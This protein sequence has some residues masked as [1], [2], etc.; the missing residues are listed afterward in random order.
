[1]FKGI[2]WFMACLLTGC[3]SYTPTLVRLDPSGLNVSKA[4]K[5]DLTLYVEEYATPSKSEIAFDEDLAE[6]GVLPL[7]IQVVNGGQDPY[8]AT[9]DDIIVRGDTVL[10]PLTPA[11]AASEAKRDAVGKAIGWS[12]IVPII[13]I[14]IAATASVIHTSK[15]NKKVVADFSA[16][17]FQGGAIQPH[18]DRSGFLFLA[19]ENGMHDLSGLNLELT[20]KNV[21]TG[22]VMVMTVPVPAASFTQ[23][24]IA[25]SPSESPGPPASPWN[26][27]DPTTAPFRMTP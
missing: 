6:E 8:E 15:V 1:M 2:S 22:E 4:V 3:A 13:A 19:L 10:K 23:K 20:A 14:P 9:A 11:E 17:A 21:E 12:L 5:G 25:I 24:A 16:K 7:L 26:E 27:D 18:Q